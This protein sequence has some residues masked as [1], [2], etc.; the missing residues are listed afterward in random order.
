MALVEYFL[1][2]YNI[3]PARVYLHGMSGG[4]ET[5]SLV[6]GMRP[7]LFAACLV[8]STRWDGDLNVLAEARTPVYMAIGDAGQLLRSGAAHE[9]VQ[10]A[11][12]HIRGAGPLGRGNRWARRSWT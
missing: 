5:A 11:A 3:D 9:R 1:A 2:E 12:R 4:G 7:E 8:T 10:R 6:M